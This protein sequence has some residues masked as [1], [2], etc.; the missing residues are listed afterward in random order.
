MGVCPR[1]LAARHEFEIAFIK[2]L[3][4]VLA[5]SA[6]WRA[7]I[8]RVHMRIGRTDQPPDVT[9]AT[10]Q[11]RALQVSQMEDKLRAIA[12]EQLQGV[13]QPNVAKADPPP[14]A[15]LLAAAG[16]SDEQP[17]GARWR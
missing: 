15:A 8:S 1:D 10:E 7:P 14:S 9:Q 3:A 5:W 12:E 16:A 4:T 17:R 2:M 11:L 13:E 6:A